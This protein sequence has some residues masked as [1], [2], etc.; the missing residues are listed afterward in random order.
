MLTLLSLHKFNE[1]DKAKLVEGL[2]DLY[3]IILPDDFTEDHLASLASSADV[4]LGMKV[5]EKVLH[6]SSH[7]QLVQTPG[8]GVDTL[9]LSPLK[10]RGVLVCNSHSNSH[11]VAEYAVTLFLALTKKMAVQTQ[12]QLPETLKEK[13][14]GILGYGKI[15]KKLSEFLGPFGCSLMV[16]RRQEMGKKD[17]GIYFTHNLKEVLSQADYI[18]VT[19]P[20]TRDTI[21]LIGNTEFALMKKSVCII[22]VGRGSV[23][24]QEA[25]YAALNEKR[26]RAAAIDVWY[27]DFLKDANTVIYSTKYPFE[28]LDNIILS[29]YKAS[30][31]EGAPHLDDVIKNLRLFATTGKVI[32]AVDLEQGY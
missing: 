2:Q 5:T 3:T 30:L 29:P 31:A 18:V 1:Q 19:L 16:F 7:L 9:S 25:L 26:I 6:N 13:V 28:K 22:N 17:S 24:D 32:N 23:I 20:L 15:G 12:E 4:L 8:A 10:K 27:D 21:G 14:V 11:Y